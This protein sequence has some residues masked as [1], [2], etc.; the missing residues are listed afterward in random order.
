MRKKGFT[1]IELLVVIAIIAILAGMLLPALGKVKEQGHRTQCASNIKQ[2][3]LAAIHYSTDFDDYVLPSNPN[4]TFAGSSNNVDCWVQGLILWGYLDKSN[5]KGNVKWGA[6]KGYATTS[7]TRPA[8]IFVCPT[9]R[10]TLENPDTTSPAPG[11]TTMYGMGTFVGSWSYVVPGSTE[12]AN[13]ARKLNQYGKHVSKV[14][15]FGDK[16]FTSKCHN[17]NTSENAEGNIFNGMIRHGG[18][19]NY[20]FFDGHAEARKP[21]QVPCH[22][23]GILYPATCDDSSA[24]YNNA[25][26]GNIGPSYI[27]YWPGS[28]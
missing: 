16:M 4:F 17:L 27:R 11:R 24:T 3:A 12:A 10:G 28:F 23:K 13:R 14:M 7:A 9:E 26:W 18:L 21:N 1:L 20:A 19:A 8:G 2:I 15:L 25:F 22:N 6:E 5:F